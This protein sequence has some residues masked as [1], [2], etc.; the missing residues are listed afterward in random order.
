MS[1]RFS[2][3]PRFLLGT[4]L[5]AILAGV[6][7]AAV[8]VILYGGEATSEEQG[9]VAQFPPPITPPSEPTLVHIYRTAVPTYPP[10]LEDYR[11]LAPEGER[12]APDL[13]PLPCRPANLEP[14]PGALATPSPEERA[15]A[16]AS[17]RNVPEGWEV[18]DNPIFRFTF[19]LPPDWY[20][21]MRPE[22][23]AFWVLNPVALANNA[24]GEGEPEP[25]GVSMTFSAKLYDPDATDRFTL[26]VA[27]PNASFG[28]YPG[29][30]WED[31]L[32]AD[33][34]FGVEKSI[35]WAFT[36][37]DLLFRGQVNFAEGADSDVAIVYQFLSTITPY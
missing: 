16:V 28:D 1:R 4:L 30:V 17:T 25:G 18:Y 12:P 5:V 10:R 15:A 35:F 32:E 8:M 13:P 29:V 21:N 26:R 33:K 6:S 9:P 23:G 19:A 11:C 14:P 36:R 31:L 37:H 27:S 20:V 3:R 24:K 22:G 7:T 34:E 2:P